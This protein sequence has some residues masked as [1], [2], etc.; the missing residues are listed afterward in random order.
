MSNP[1]RTNESVLAVLRAG[2]YAVTQGQI[3]QVGYGLAT[4]YDASG[5]KVDAWQNAIKAHLGAHRCTLEIDS[6]GAHTRY[7]WRLKAALPSA[8]SR[9]PK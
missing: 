4:L 9:S 7:V 8:P 3:G 5:A 6:S 2:G 1:L